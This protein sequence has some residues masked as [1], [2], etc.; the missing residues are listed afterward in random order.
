MTAA[1]AILRRLFVLAL[2]AV[3]IV[4]WFFSIPYI[5]AAAGN[6]SAA[7][8]VVCYGLSLLAVPA[9][10]RLVSDAFDDLLDVCDL[11]RADRT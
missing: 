7:T 9:F 2:F 1:F 3:A 10:A 11:L 4:V 5:V 6:E 8:T